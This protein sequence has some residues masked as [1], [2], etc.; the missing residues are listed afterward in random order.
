MTGPAHKDHPLL[1]PLCNSWPQLVSGRARVLQCTDKRERERERERGERREREREK[2]N[3]RESQI[4]LT[5]S[6]SCRC[7]V[8]NLYVAVAAQTPN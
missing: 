1:F 6:V 8:C 3:N 5:K 7:L 4:T 2:E